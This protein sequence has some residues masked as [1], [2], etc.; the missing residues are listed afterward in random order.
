MELVP[1]VYETLI[2]EAI[3]ERLIDKSAKGYHIAKEK[4]DSADSNTFFANYLAGIVSNIL[5]DIKRNNSNETISEQIKRINEIF[6][7]DKYGEI[8]TLIHF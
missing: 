6:S 7:E 4:I 8:T 5:K 1:G 2:S 3:Q